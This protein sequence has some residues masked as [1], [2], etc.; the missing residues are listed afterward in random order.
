MLILMSGVIQLFLA[1]LK[2]EMNIY[3]CWHEISNVKFLNSR[4]CLEHNRKP[5]INYQKWFLNNPHKM[6]INR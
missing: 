2:D 4:I 6:L 5:G 3:F 1:I